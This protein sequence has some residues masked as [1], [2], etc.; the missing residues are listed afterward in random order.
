MKDV[1]AV[2]FSSV[3]AYNYTCAVSVYFHSIIFPE[4]KSTYCD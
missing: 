3:H 1:E 2:S 4:I